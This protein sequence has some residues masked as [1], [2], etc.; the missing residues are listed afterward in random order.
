MFITLKNMKKSFLFVMM[1]AFALAACQ[2]GG[3]T[4]PDVRTFGFTGDVK[5]VFL[6]TMDPDL[7]EE[8]DVD[9]WLEEEILEFSF[10]AQ[11]RVNEDDYGNI[12]IYDAEGNLL[13]NESGHRT[14]TRD[15]QGRF[16]SYVNEVLDDDGEFY[17]E[18][19][20]VF[21][22]CDI[23]YTYD[24]KGRRVTEEYGGW[25]WGATYTYEYKGDAFY[26]I[27]VSYESYSEGWND[28]GTIDYEYLEFDDKGNW[29]VR[30]VHRVSNS[31]EEPWEEDME[32]EIE[33][34]ETNTR[35]Y[36]KITYWSDKD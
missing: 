9:P 32:P 3:N 2:K 23:T 34:T 20:D 26:P 11:G 5:E 29:T 21:D 14:L 10:D 7:L 4:S 13:D 6:S 33:T 22:S 18:D 35:E 25:E 17:D 27:R 16:L 8:D 1:A 31:Y 30:N 12:F 28:D 15:G 19:A 36:H 24:A